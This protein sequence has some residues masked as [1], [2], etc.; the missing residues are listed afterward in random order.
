[1]PGKQVLGKTE[2]VPMDQVHG[3]NDCIQESGMGRR[4]HSPF[5]RSTEVIED[6]LCARHC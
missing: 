3:L 5:I 2:L 1:M 6:L 4:G